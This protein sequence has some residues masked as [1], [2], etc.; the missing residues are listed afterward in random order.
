MYPVIIELQPIDLLER[1]MKHVVE[2]VDLA[3]TMGFSINGFTDENDLI[4]RIG[5]MEISLLSD[6]ITYKDRNAPP[7]MIFSA[8]LRLEKFNALAARI[9]DALHVNY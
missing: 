6:V 2:L 1:R 8:E 7:A 4:R 5:I 9:F 3:E